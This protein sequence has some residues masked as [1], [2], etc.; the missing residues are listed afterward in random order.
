[1][2][3]ALNINP[4]KEFWNCLLKGSNNLVITTKCNINCCF[5]SRKFNPFPTKSYHR[6]FNEI[7]EEVKMFIP[8]RMKKINTSISR[9]T[10]GE[11]FTHPR[12]WDILELI[13]KMYPYRRSPRLS[14]KIMI[15]TNGT[16][17]TED[18]LKKL[19]ELKGIII[20]HS[21]NGTDIEDWIKLS[22]ST[23]KFAEIAT[24]V[25]K[26]I[27]NFDI[28]Y[29]PSIVAMPKIVGYDGIERTIRDLYKYNVKSIR[30]FLPTYTKYASKEEQEMLYCDENELINLID[31]LK[32]ELQTNIWLYPVTYADLTPK[33]HG[34]E[35]FG[36]NPS[37]EILHINSKKIFSRTHATNILL[38][39]RGIVEIM[40]KTKDGQIKQINLD[41]LKI[42]LRNYLDFL[43]NE[44]ITFT[45]ETI[46]EKVRKYQK[47]LVAHSEAGERIVKKAF[48]KAISWNEKL[49]KKKFYFQTVYN[50]FYGGN[51]QCSG[52]LLCQDY[53]KYIKKFIDENFKPDVVLMTH[54]TFDL[55][56]RDLL[57]NHIYDVCNELDI[58]FELI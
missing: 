48:E 51:V 56:G 35:N 45:P 41:I 21:I 29:M 3:N 55:S 32:E 37:D 1:M 39:S 47:I 8:Y 43:V 12:I 22:G 38:H 7:V 17:L 14:D 40:I 34:L 57:N 10:D 2:N 9:M 33:L 4:R 25:P 19:E 15:T 6:D 44:D 23:R 26:L 42:H 54:D 53:K 36:I 16:Y 58:K 18:N 13:R 24:N 11:P 5:C 49:K 46:E 52:L 30:V 20:V 50:D 28:E 27:K 31:K